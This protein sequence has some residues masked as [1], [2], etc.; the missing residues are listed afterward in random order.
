MLIYSVWLSKKIKK[1]YEYLQENTRYVGVQL[2]IGGWQP[3][4]A[5]FVD[6]KKYGDCKALSNYTKALLKATGINSYYT[7]VKA[8]GNEPDILYDFPS[9]QFNHVFLCVPLESDTVWLEC[10]SQTNP[11]GYLGSFTS[12]R[13]VLLITEDG[14]KL[15]RTPTY[16]T[17]QNK[18]TTVADVYIDKE[19][20]AKV[21]A[22]INCSG[23][24][25]E[26]NYFYQYVN[27]SYDKQKKWLYQ[28]LDISGVIIDEFSLSAA[29]EIVPEGTMNLDLSVPKY[30]SVNG[31][32][33]FI[34]PN[35]LSKSGYIPDKV[36]ERNSNV[37]IKNSGWDSD[38][39][40]FHIP[41]GF[42]IEFKP[43]TIDIESE[44][45]AYHSEIT[46]EENK[47]T[48]LRTF[49]LE[50]GTYPPEKYEDLREYLR[51]V[52]KADKS[53]IVF[54]NRT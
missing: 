12:D 50:A 51:Q 19:G 27:E 9:R 16:K 38:S 8:G 29:G 28:T 1:V 36:E 2:G 41:E 30:A 25:F 22:T 6:E 5:S 3:F 17:A 23:L 14:G 43:E 45:G 32:R 11:F 18:K 39:I 33:M 7:L 47:V 40:V 21:S 4:K 13:H 20:L 34:Q 52:V 49:K 31:K 10:T 26:N 24:Q 44:F 37:Y 53:K 42:H 46:L 15:V 48:L 54:V 35:I